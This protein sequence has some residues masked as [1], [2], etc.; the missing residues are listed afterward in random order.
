MD[1]IPIFSQRS[2]S[3]ALEAMAGRAMLAEAKT[4]KRVKV[5]APTNR[6]TEKVRQRRASVAKMLKR[7]ERRYD[8]AQALGISISLLDQDISW[9]FAAGAID[10]DTRKASCGGRG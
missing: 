5:Q 8:V 10:E 1:V 7:G 4:L 2:I 3:P 6:P 9:L